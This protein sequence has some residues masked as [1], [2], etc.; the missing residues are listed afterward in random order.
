MQPGEPGGVRQQL[1]DAV[2]AANGNDWPDPATGQGKPFPRPLRR[3]VAR[4]RTHDFIF[5]FARTLQ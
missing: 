2:L 1:G 3:G 4:S 5:P